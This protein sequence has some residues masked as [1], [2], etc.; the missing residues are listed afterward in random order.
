MMRAQQR[1]SIPEMDGALRDVVR[2][3]YPEEWTLSE[4]I[5]KH[6]SEGLGQHIDDDEIAYLTMHIHYIIKHPTAA[7]SERQG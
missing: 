5:V 2:D 7:T 6:V 4:G 3:K 1:E